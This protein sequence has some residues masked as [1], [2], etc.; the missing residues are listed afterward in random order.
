MQ[1]DHLDMLETERGLLRRQ[2]RQVQRMADPKAPW[3]GDLPFW[4][5]TSHVPA[6][7]ERRRG[8]QKVAP[9][10]YCLN[11]YPFQ[12]L[13]IAA[14]ELPLSDELV[15][16]LIARTGRALDEFGRWIQTRRPPDWL[17]RM[18][19]FLP[20]S[21]AVHEE[22]LR[23][24]L[25]KSEDPEVKARQKL[26]AKVYVDMTPEVKDELT[27]EGRVT[28]ARS[29]LR[30]V[31]SHRKLALSA[32]EQARIE[33]CSDLATLERWFEKAMDAS[34]AAEALR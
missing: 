5:A 32:E 10:C 31:L 6:V 2:A 9:G 11:P 20:M 4:M 16:F 7:L 27:A 34:S 33:A 14:N 18:V 22:L 23:F 17:S 15:P 3:D 24:V 12:F 26:I 28:E 29:A 25:T 1:G 13:W 19:E 30:R 21:T 8:L